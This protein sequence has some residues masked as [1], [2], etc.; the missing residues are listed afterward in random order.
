MNGNLGQTD[1]EEDVTQVG[2]RYEKP[3]S[4]GKGEDDSKQERM[5]QETRK[6]KNPTNYK[7]GKYCNL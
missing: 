3:G 4:Q 1:Q 6:Q 2:W 7:K 5:E